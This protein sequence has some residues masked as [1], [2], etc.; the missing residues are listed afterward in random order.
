MGAKFS[1]NQNKKDPDRLLKRKYQHAVQQPSTLPQSDAIK[2]L[3]DDSSRRTLSIGSLDSRSLPYGTLKGEDDRMNANQFALKALFEG[4]FLKTVGE[5]IDFASTSTKVLD[6]GCGAGGWIMVSN[7]SL[8]R[9]YSSVAC[10]VL[11]HL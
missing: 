2:D 11:D 6:I 1:V 4:N 8:F 9:L 7:C 10:A 3:K 5:N